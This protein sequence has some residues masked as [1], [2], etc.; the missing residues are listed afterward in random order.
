MVLD[1]HNE[2]LVNEIQGFNTLNPEAY[3]QLT[4][5]DLLDQFS[6]QFLFKTGLMALS[7]VIVMSY[8]QYYSIQIE[9]A[10]VKLEKAA[11]EKIEMPRKDRYLCLISDIFFLA[12][13]GYSLIF[14][15]F[16]TGWF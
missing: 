5:N 16:Y 6:D 12:S 15:G 14:I 2:T 7:F 8:L 13:V 11:G 4:S 9:K 3:T 1:V 10:H